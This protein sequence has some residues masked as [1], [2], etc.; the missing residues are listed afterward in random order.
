MRD[1]LRNDLK[2]G[3]VD[4]ARS[5]TKARSSDER[6]DAVLHLLRSGAFGRYERFK[7]L[8]ESFEGAK[9]YYLV[10]HDFGAYLDAMRAAD[11]LYANPRE[12]TRRSILCTARMGRFSADRSVEKYVREIW[13]LGKLAR[14]VE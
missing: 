5:A 13:G 4:A 14:N 3:E 6:L 1:D 9:D 10:G 12:W 11:V 8:V 7:A 2:V